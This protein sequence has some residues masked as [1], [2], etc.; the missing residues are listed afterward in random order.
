MNNEYSQAQPD[1]RSFL[2]PGDRIA[3]CRRNTSQPTEFTIHGLVGYGGTAVCYL[4]EANGQRGRLK[5]FYP[6]EIPQHSIYYF[7]QRSQTNQLL[8]IG[9]GMGQRFAAMCHDFIQ[10]YDTL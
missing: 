8:P 2:R 6:H 4:A 3:L 1:S 10:A 9:D 5:E 7:L